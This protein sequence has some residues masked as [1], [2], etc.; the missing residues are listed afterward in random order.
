MTDKTGFLSNKTVLILAG[1]SG[2]GFEIAQLAGAQGAK[3]IIVGRDEDKCEHAA[4]RL[5]AGGSLAEGYAL[6]A[7]DSDALRGLLEAIGPVDHAVSMVGGA[8]GGGFLA[9]DMATIRN[10]IED[11]FFSNLQIARTLA[12]YLAE[13]GSLTLTAGSGGRPDNASGA[14]VGNEGISTLV[15]GLAV[16]L[17]PRARANAVAPTWTPTP[18]WRDV[19]A[20]EVE[21]TRLRFAGQIPLARTGK[22]REVALAYLFLM[23]C[24]FITGQTIIVDGGL[25]LIS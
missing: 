23:Q 25:A 9:A 7:T 12:P 3:L 17:A 1:S 5:Q 6:N 21:A 10:A 19:P 11:K 20:A 15:R 13:T 18:L 8:M 16:E 24:G 22:P 14:I 2:F 4:A